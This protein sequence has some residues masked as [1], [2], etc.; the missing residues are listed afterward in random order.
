MMAGKIK[1]ISISVHERLR[2]MARE[3]SRPFNELLQH[4]AIERFIYRLSK[5]PYADR[6][7]LKGALM[8]LAWS[9][10]ASRPTMDIDL[11]GK[12]DNSIEKI[13]MVMKQACNMDV[14]EDGMIF[15]EHTVSAAKITE[16]AEYEG[17][18]VRIKGNLGKARVS[19]QIDIGFGDVV[20]PDPGRVAYPVLLEFPPPELNGYTMES[21]IAEK[22]QA[23]VKL[24]ILNSRMKDFYDI[25]L[26]SH[27]FDFD[28]EVLAEAVNRT[29]KN[30]KTDL[31]TEP[32]VFDPSFGKDSSKQAQ[33]QAFVKK[34]RLSNA[35]GEFNAVLTDMK[36]FL[37][38][39]ITSL[40]DRQPFHGK[41]KASG[42]WI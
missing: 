39:L 33:W 36:M 26:L 34:T 37:G 31:N 40:V 17:T 20:V 25:W 14:E 16:D 21:T 2:N 42:P 10:P 32:A 12:I 7:I 11:L 18:R 27:T 41:W 30:R 28:G 22:Y 1:N 3:S 38:P 29:F 8:F 35:P 5:S 23:M 4:F 15:H 19:L 24:G 6:F 9:G 13:E